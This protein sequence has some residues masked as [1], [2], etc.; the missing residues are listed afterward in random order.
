MFAVG[1][2]LCVLWAAAIDL[3]DLRRGRVRRSV[4]QMLRIRSD[5]RADS[6]STQHSGMPFPI[7]GE[8]RDRMAEE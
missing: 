4:S 2:A 6:W 1:L 5:T 3:H 8:V 7:A